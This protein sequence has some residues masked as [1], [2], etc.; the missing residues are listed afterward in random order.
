MRISSVLLALSVLVFSNSGFADSVECNNDCDLPN[1]IKKCRQLAG[2]GQI[3]DFNTKVHCRAEKTG[4]RAAGTNERKLSTRFVVSNMAKMKDGRYELPEVRYQLPVAPFGAQCPVYEE[5]AAATPYLVTTLET[6]EALEA[7]AV[8][9]RDKFC[10]RVVEES[11]GLD[12]SEATPTGKS[13]ILCGASGSLAQ[14]GMEELGV[15]LASITLAR[16][17]GD[18][19]CSKIAEITDQLGLL[20]KAGLAVGDTL[21]TANGVAVKDIEVLAQII[22]EARSL[23][24]AEIALEVSM[25][26]RIKTIQLK[27]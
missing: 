21:I 14:P 4:W 9:G 26:N 16:S 17:T 7:M 25:S 3:R 8:E 5:V 24:K 27:I 19:A 2:D 20:A 22:Q 11:G 12:M 6:C 1:L 10:A 13:V 23:Q 15:A 18:I